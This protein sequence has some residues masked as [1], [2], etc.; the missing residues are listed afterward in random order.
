VLAVVRGSA[1]NQDG[2]TS[3]LTAPNGPSQQR[4]IRA[5]LANAG[6]SAAEV[7]V[8]EGHGTG[9]TLGDPIEAQALLAT[10]GQE[11]ESENPVWLGSVK[12]N[13]GHTMAAAGVAGVIKMV[14]ALRHGVLPQTLH[15]DEPSTH[16]D[17]TSGAVE[18]LSEQRQWPELDR[19]RRAAVSSF[20]FSGTNAHTILEQAPAVVDV[21]AE[22]DAEPVVLPGVV[23]WLVSAKSEEALDM[24]VSRLRSFVEGDELSDAVARVNVGLS[25]EGRSLFEHRAVLLASDEGVSECARGVALESKL[26]V[27][28]SGQGSQRLGMGR[29]L[30]ERFPVFAEAFDEV[31][32][33]LDRQLGGLLEGQQDGQK[34]GQQEGQ[35]SG[36]LR[37]VVW[38]EDAELLNQTGWAQPALFAVEVAL[39]ALAKSWGV[40][41]HFVA[42]H[43]IG[44]VS[45]AYVA[46]V[47]SLEDACVLVGARAQLMQA[48][49]AGGVMVA[50]GA[51]EAEVLPLLSE[52]VSIAAVNGPQSVVISGVAE[53]V[54]LVVG[55]LSERRS[56][57]LS[58]SHGFH[59]PLMDPMLGEFEA[60]VAGLTFQEPVIPVISN[61]TGELATAEQLCSAKYW[62]RHVREAVRFADGVTALVGAGVGAF[63][64]LGPDGVLC[65]MAAEVAADATVVPVLRKDVAE[66]SAALTAL[67]RLHVSGVGVDWAG[68]FTG[69]GGRR[70][71]LPTYAFQ[72]ERFWPESTGA[73]SVRAAADP[74]D[75]E[76]WAAVES[77]DVESLS[78]DLALESGVVTSLVSA[79]ASWRRRRRDQRTMDQWQYQ[80]AWKPLAGGTGGTGGAGGPEGSDGD[81]G[82]APW[83]VLVPVG[84]DG[85]DGLDPEWVAGVVGALG[86]DAVR[87]DVES[88]SRESLAAAVVG[89]FVGVVSL[90]G[91]DESAGVAGTCSL[92][93]ALGDVGVAAPLWAVTCG[94]VSVGAT[95]R[96]GSPRQAG[97]WGL[98]RV[99]GL[100]HP[101]LWGGVIDLPSVMDQQAAD[102]FAGVL[103]GS[104][105]QVAV[106]AEGVFGR[107]LVPAAPGTPQPWE[108]SGTVL[109]TGATGGPGGHVARWLAGAGVQHLVLASRGGPD[110]PGAQE[111][112]DELVELGVGVS[113]VA[114]DV[115]D[116]EA[117]AAVLDAIPAERPLTGVIHAASVLAEGSLDE[118]TPELFEKVYQAKVD[119]ALVLDELTRGLD[120]S[121]F[122]LF[123]SLAG[124]VGNLGLGCYASANAVLDALARQRH[125]DGLPATALAFALW[126]GEGISGDPDLGE[127]SRR[128]GVGVLEPEL[129]ISILSSAVIGA[130]P[131]V[132]VADLQEKRSLAALLSIRPSPLL[133]DLP[134]AKRINEA[135]AAGS[136][137][138]QSAGSQIREHLLA[139][140]EAKRAGLLVDLVR[141]QAAAVLGHASTNTLGADKAFKTL[142]VD[143]L[144]A[145]E[146]RNKLRDA[147]GLSLTASLVFD[148]P[149]P[150]VL[151]R[152]LQGEL[153]G[154]GTEVVNTQQ[155]SAVV[156]DEPIAIVGMG[157]RFP[158]GVTS[159]E[160]LWDLVVSGGDAVG[161]FPSDRGWDLELLAG[162]GPGSSITNEGGFVDDVA[163]FDAGFFG[164]SP[165]EALAMDPQQR[166][167]LETTWEALERAG[168]DP[169]S[170]SGSQ[171]GVFAGTNGQDYINLVATAKEDLAGHSM[172]GLSASVVS[173]RLSYALGL[174]GPAVT[175]DTAC[176]SS[177]V[178]LHLA[179]QSLRAGECSLA[180]AGGVTVMAT[181]SY[182]AGFTLQGG[183]SPD[184]RCK[185]YSEAADGTGWGEGVGVLVVERLSD[186]RRNGHE[187][188][189]VVRGSAVNQDGASNGLTAPNG[190]A[191]RR[192]ILAALANAGVSAAEVDVVEGHGTG[193][194]L[195]DPIEAQALL[196]TYG[197]DR[198]P[199]RPLLLGS[200]KSNIGHTMAAA[201]VSG[202]IKMVMAMR[203]GLLPQTLHLDEPSSHVDWSSG[204][205]SL[206][207][208]TTPWPQ[209]DRPRRG[210]VSSFGFSGT[211][212]HTILEQAP[213]LGE[214]VAEPGEP[215]EE[216]AAAPDA[217]V[218]E[219][220]VVPWLVS[221]KTE[222]ALDLQVSR[223]RSVVE[224]ERA[225]GR[226]DVGF[227]LL[228][229]SGFDHRAVLLATEEGVSEVARGVAEDPSLA[230][231]FSGQG[232]QRLGMGRGLYERFPVFAKAFDE[233]VELLDGQLVGL[234]Q[235][236][237]G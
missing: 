13:I 116:R 123:S 48:L 30:Y 4:V 157:C 205:I 27:L 166:L 39:F 137:N 199:A 111:L 110:A 17:W 217:P 142:G 184:G 209:T 23:P 182:F 232:S 20:G 229:R 18:L 91:L 176:S 72:H 235:G 81:G 90:L 207:S 144:G 158:G 5:A 103:D 2:A 94:A 132:V 95:D 218:V 121:V 163:D 177:L 219:L 143:S 50:L 61:L 216:P 193:T 194:K 165:R 86:S 96:I 83:L 77:E 118:M 130:E 64:E 221:A 198:D 114:C 173:G 140:P 119:S 98:G 37:D 38:G 45:A 40:K 43:S 44:E 51:T 22:P 202:V 65:A 7:D 80:E 231:L 68:F 47:F 152:Y 150:R 234:L 200:I 127:R 53:A 154:E 172:T 161:H 11:R 63:F 85:L 3:G 162:G 169:V 113:I 201:G 75:D 108:P 178:A 148:Y 29:G 33:L 133:G 210:A 141:T 42:G 117:V 92:V 190:P 25:L 146:I 237:A 54:D 215:G 69:T 41:V 10:Y 225:P 35:A 9:T 206:L 78:S 28:F 155:Q 131:V 179:V 134:E 31:V 100:E 156:H 188:L 195:G 101:Q 66:E 135:A 84:L 224:G 67:G 196:A 73:F 147:T 181:P 102:R 180:L 160:A 145:I 58:V 115:A 233:V 14:M 8:V 107:R 106:R 197:T 222:T 212:A 208:E 167:L 55:Q 191:Q 89:E 52:G 6:V 126:A 129:A 120:L 109:I 128:S 82:D 97:V 189:A 175:V 236:R 185:S 105:D 214:L 104:E 15:I 56:K 192:V 204:A 24:Q 1:I 59:S 174:E 26:A 93:Q 49:P 159:P 187:V 36:S 32:E 74:V 151:A 76:F 12:S 223:L 21:A 122:A 46:G 230:V 228:G 136:Q 16:V 170:L 79:L 125:A 220:D 211:N 19:P 60:V 186:A 124:S 71:D 171:T 227:S 226:L 112:S 62:V 149:S 88:L 168:I 70:V 57:K 87:V 138:S 164:I 203:H 99:I 213:L 153:L 183:L 34:E 139:L